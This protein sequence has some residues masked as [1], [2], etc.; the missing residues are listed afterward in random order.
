M[1]HF[2]QASP[3]LGLNDQLV[4]Q[5]AAAPLD[6]AIILAGGESLQGRSDW[7]DKR[8]E[9]LELGLQAK[10]TASCEDVRFM[11]ASLEFRDCGDCACEPRTR[12]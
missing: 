12:L 3:F 4:R 7:R 5:I 8:Q 6:D 2:W 9:L 10:A 11:S 1:E